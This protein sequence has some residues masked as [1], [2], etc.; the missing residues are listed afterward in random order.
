MN[1]CTKFQVDIFKK[2]LRYDIKHVTRGHSCKLVNKFAKTCLRQSFFTNRVIDVCNS[3][4]PL[5]INSSSLNEFK[6]MIDT[7]FSDRGLV[8]DTVDGL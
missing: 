5:A 8:Y 7:Y 1:M 4:P 2:W 3:L 6:N